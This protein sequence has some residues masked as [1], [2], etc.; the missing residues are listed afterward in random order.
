MGGFKLA[1]DLAGVMKKGDSEQKQGNQLQPE[2]L[3]IYNKI[4]HEMIERSS[5]GVTSEQAHY[6]EEPFKQANQYDTNSSSS[7]GYGFVPPPEMNPN[8]II[9]NKEKSSTPV[10][11]SKPGLNLGFKLNLE[12]VENANIITKEDKSR[13]HILKEMSQ[14][15]SNTVNLNIID[16]NSSPENEYNKGMNQTTKT[17]FQAPRLPGFGGLGGGFKID[18]NKVPEAK[19]IT[20]EDKEKQRRLNGNIIFIALVDSNNYV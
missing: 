7:S 10:P 3:N 9:K 20:E 13:V 4:E 19:V 5:L 11:F 18:L 14:P 6:F 17:P 16:Q 1:L 2:K 15:L 12:N 8:L